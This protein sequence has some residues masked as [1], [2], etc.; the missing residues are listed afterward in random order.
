MEAQK[1]SEMY[2]WTCSQEANV[3]LESGIG[4][5]P[6][7]CV[8][9]TGEIEYKEQRFILAHGSRGLSLHASL[10]LLLLSL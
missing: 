4:P 1:V 2:S 9:V 6:K 3:S 10:F 7:F 5:F 8:A